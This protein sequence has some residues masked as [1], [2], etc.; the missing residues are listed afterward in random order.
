MVH[1][2][3]SGGSP[4]RRAESS[5]DA[6]DFTVRGALDDVRLDDGALSQAETKA[7]CTPATS[8]CGPFST[9]MALRNSAAVHGVIAPLASD[10]RLRRNGDTT[11]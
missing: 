5:V 4:R 3:T 10:E 6:R 9:I 11:V 7:L 8:S 1:R 2:S